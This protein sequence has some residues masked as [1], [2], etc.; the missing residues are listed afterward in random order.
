ML[1]ALTVR[2]APHALCRAPSVYYY[3]HIYIKG[4]EYSADK[5][6]V[7]KLEV[8]N[9]DIK[10]RLGWQEKVALGFIG[11]SALQTAN[12]KKGEASIANHQ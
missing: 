1:S 11:H 4:N 5:R 6:G 8:A 9:R 10:F 7:Q 3:K 2:R 12:G